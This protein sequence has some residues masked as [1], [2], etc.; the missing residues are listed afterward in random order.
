M[1]FLT[2]FADQA[3]VLPL[4][5]A[6]ALVFAA[7]GWWRGL[8]AWLL[9]VAGVL[10]TILVLKIA[11][12]ACP[13]AAATGIRSPS[14]HTASAGIVYGGIMLLLLRGRVSRP[15]LLLIPVA[16]ALVFGASR[17]A[18]GVHTPGDVVAGGLVGLAGVAALARLSGPMSVRHQG[19]LV[20][21]LLL[22]MALFHGRHLGAEEAIHH[23]DLQAW[24]PTDWAQPLDRACRIG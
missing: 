12:G 8:G 4:A 11:F 20:A 15:V 14:G 1:Q 21:T 13:A 23:F 19:R 7:S 24:L 18:L 2:D 22:L 6:T 16:A 17:L 9:A 3:V 10:G 5:L